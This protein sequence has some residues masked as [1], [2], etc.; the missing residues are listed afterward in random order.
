MPEYSELPKNV[1]WFI[2]SLGEELV[3]QI[4]ESPIEGIEVRLYINDI[5]VDNPIEVLD[6]WIGV[7]D[8]EV[9]E[10]VSAT[11]KKLVEDKYGEFI[12]SLIYSARNILNTFEEGEQ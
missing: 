9:S 10:Y 6:E 11:V 12:E 4:V 7:A 5:L 8:K 3:N 1:Q 2:C